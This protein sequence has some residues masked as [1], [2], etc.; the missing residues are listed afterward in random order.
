L[1]IDVSKF[2]PTQFNTTGRVTN[3]ERTAET[4][5]DYCLSCYPYKFKKSDDIIKRPQIDEHSD[6]DG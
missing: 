4:E 6:S 5:E 1:R 2:L 3:L